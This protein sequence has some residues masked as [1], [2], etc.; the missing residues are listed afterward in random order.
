MTVEAWAAHYVGT[1]K[2]P[3]VSAGSLPGIDGRVRNYV[4]PAM[5]AMRMKVVKKSHCQQALNA[6]AGMSRSQADKLRHLLYG[7]FDAAYEDGLTLD[8]PARRL[9]LPKCTA[10]THRALSAREREALLAVCASHRHGLWA[11]LMLRCG[12]RPGETARVMG[13][14]IDLKAR[15]LYVDGTKSAAARRSVPLPAQLLPLLADAARR[16]FGLVFTNGR[17]GP[18]N[19]TNRRRMWSAL[20][21]DMNI[22]M[23]CRVFR[24]ALVPPLPLAADVTPY[25]LRHTYATDLQTAGVPVNVAKVLLGH[26]DVSTTGNIYTHTSEESFEAARRMID[27]HADKNSHTY[28]HT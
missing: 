1:Y 25:S 21:R 13:S 12:L 3:S 19:E 22:W 27:A 4:L 15:T 7:I 5:G 6:A 16:P 24:N 14:H 2:A 18:V 20:T 26:E 9:T 28:S 11:L 10:G 17:G 8:N 23:G